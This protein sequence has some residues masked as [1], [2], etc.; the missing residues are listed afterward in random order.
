MQGK[1]LFLIVEEGKFNFFHGDF[2]PAIPEELNGLFAYGAYETASG[3]KIFFM[4]RLLGYNSNHSGIKL[5]LEGLKKVDRNTFFAT[6][7]KQEQ[8]N[9]Y[10]KGEPQFGGEMLLLNG[11]FIF[12]NFKSTVYS[13][14]KPEYNDANPELEQTVNSSLLPPERFVKA[15]AAE[16]FA[17]TS[18]TLFFESN[19]QYKTPELASQHA[20]RICNL[21]QLSPI[22]AALAEDDATPPT[23]VA[24]RASG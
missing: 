4:Q 2:S 22:A 16:A 5:I 10:K 23:P 14:S 15:S 7:E 6:P 13:R 21:L 1:L 24:I 17:Q 19:G 12:W 9:K 18:M 8:F 3:E 20:L 11:E